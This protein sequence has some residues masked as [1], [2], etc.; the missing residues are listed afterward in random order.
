MCSMYQSCSSDEVNMNP[1]EESL[2]KVVFKDDFETFDSNVWTK[3]EHE[4]GWVNQELQ[5]YDAAHVST[6]TDEGRSVLIL[7]AERKGNKIYSGR[8]N[9]Q[10]KKSFQYGT[11]DSPSYSHRQQ[12][13]VKFILQMFLDSLFVLLIIFTALYYLRMKE[14][15]MRHDNC[16]QYTHNNEHTSLRNTWCHPRTC[17]QSPVDVYQKQFVKKRK[18]DNRYESNDSPFYTPVSLYVFSIVSVVWLL[19]SLTSICISWPICVP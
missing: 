18:T 17:S 15:I 6:G 7:T 5:I 3:E 11:V 16:S 10:G 1:Q 19:P 12:R 14:Q 9:S 4:A 13:I 8:V 2:E